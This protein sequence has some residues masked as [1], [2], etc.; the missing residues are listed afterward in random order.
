MKKFTATMSGILMGALVLSGCGGGSGNTG[1]AAGNTSDT[2]SGSSSSPG[3]PVVIT[4]FN[5]KIEIAEQL[6]ALKAD[7]EAG[8]PNVKLEIETVFENY[9][10]ALKTKFAAKQM[11]DLFALEGYSGM[12][13]WTDELEDLSG[14]P[15]MKDVADAA[16]PGMTFDGKLYGL[17]LGF[18]GYGYLYNK[19]LFQKAGIT[20]V[21]TTFTELEE[22]AKKLEAIGVKPFI[23]QASSYFVPGV[24]SVNNAFAKQ[25]DPDAFIKGLNEGS[26]TFVGNKIFEDWSRLAKFEAEHSYGNPLTL[27]YNAVATEFAQGNGAMTTLGNWAEG[28][29]RSMNPD[30]HIGLMPA[31]LNDDEKLNDNLFV[32][33][34]RYWV[35]NNKSKVKK[36]AEEFL[37][38]LVTSDTGKKYMTQEFKFI[39]AMKSIQ[40]D[41]ANIGETGVDVQR[42]VQE[43]KVLQ[44]EWPKYPEGVTQDIGTSV[45]KLIGGK[46]DADTMLQQFQ[47]AWDVAKSKK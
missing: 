45:Q 8:H 25:P 9:D 27:D 12:S 22:A 28:T 1:G 42:Y 6:K 39:P 5:H 26:A 34:P 3:N 4:F 30:M 15:W 10:T 38:W 7:Y 35:I 11:P 23:D 14:Q 40:A 21:P 41:A 32:G 47:A 19:D 31:P 24:H 43:G 18:E 44:W 46:I 29:I 16:K 2:T 20:K 17:P 33:V 37:N 13:I 36:E